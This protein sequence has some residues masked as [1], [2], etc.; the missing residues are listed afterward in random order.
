MKK[1]RDVDNGNI[2]VSAKPGCVRC[3]DMQCCKCPFFHFTKVCMEIKLEDYLL[4]GKDLMKKLYADEIIE[5]PAKFNH[6][7]D[8]LNKTIMFSISKKLAKGEDWRLCKL[9]QTCTYELD[10]GLVIS[11]RGLG[12]DEQ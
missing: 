11:N 8:K 2:I 9:Y 7:I 10:N 12:D 1:I 6:A 3:V 5:A 4:E